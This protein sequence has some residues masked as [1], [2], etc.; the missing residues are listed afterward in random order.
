MLGERDSY[1]LC[2]GAAG[3]TLSFTSATPET[4]YTSGT[5]SLYLTGTNFDFLRDLTTYD[6][7]LRSMA[8]RPDVT[9]P[10]QNIFVDTQA[11]TAELVLDQEL[12]EGTWQVIFDWKDP[13][14]LDSTGE[15]LRFSVSS[16]PT[17]KNTVYGVLAIEKTSG[18]ENEFQLYAYETEEEYQSAFANTDSMDINLLEFRGSFSLTYDGETIVGAK[19]TAVE[20]G[21]SINISDCL[22]VDNGW[23]EI[24][25]EDP[26]TEEQSILVDIDGEVYT[27]GARTKVWDGACALS[28]IENGT[29]LSKYN[30]IGN[31][32]N[33]LT[34]L[35]SEMVSAGT[36]KV[37]CPQT[38][39][40]DILVA[41]RAVLFGFAGISLHWGRCTAAFF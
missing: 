39:E 22:D 30:N 7:R 5:R 21:D 35:H 41:I 11:N 36:N 26:G 23:V 12:E 14:K 13:S 37:I 16:S 40:R 17:F 27:T 1:V 38:A 24:T 28:A 20:G 34:G 3:E 29:L 9:V 18:M 10:A 33:T 8:G 15:A 2:P 31:H 6:V 19:A 32:L 4:I 25:V